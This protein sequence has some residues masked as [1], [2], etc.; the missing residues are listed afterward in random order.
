MLRKSWQKALAETFEGQ[1]LVAKIQLPAVA[2]IFR[3]G[4]WL[5]VGAFVGFVAPFVQLPRGSVVPRTGCAICSAPL[6]A[7]LSALAGT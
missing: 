3:E 4:I 5:S 6:L 1:L 2:E 7:G